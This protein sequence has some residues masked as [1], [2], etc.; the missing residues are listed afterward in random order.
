M[1]TNTN[2][3]VDKKIC[4]GTQTYN[5]SGFSRAGLKTAIMISNLD[6]IFD[7][8]FHDNHFVGIN[9]ILISHGHIDHV[10]S[11]HYN[12]NAKKLYNITKPK[13]YIMP[14]QCINPYKMIASG[15]S[16]M[17]CGRCNS[18]INIFTELLLT[19]LISCEDSISEYINLNNNMYYKAFEMDHKILSF[20][21]IIYRKSNKLKEEYK[22][23]TGKEIKILKDS[24]III[25]DEIFEPLVG[26]T[27]DTS[28]NGLI[29]NP[30]FL[31]VPLLIMECTGLSPDDINEVRQGY[32]IHLNDIKD[33]QG[34]LQNEKILLF[35]FS[36]K[37]RT[38][39]D[40]TQ[41]INLL[42]EPLKSKIELLF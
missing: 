4:V 42:D 15:F 39:E 3:L 38:L 29:N 2:Q 35:H 6:L 10:G 31:T 32:H 11:L 5:I 17:N 28:F 41:Y 20:G 34:I 21:F 36:Q 30:I 18:K 25:T 33:N 40:V 22:S 26:Y 24:E 14:D 1:T 7:Y 13:K 19:T 9:N 23:K 8:G 27:G 37:Y 16:Y 12:H